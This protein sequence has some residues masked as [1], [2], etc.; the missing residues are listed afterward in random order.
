MAKRHWKRLGDSK[1]G[2]VEVDAN[3]YGPNRFEYDDKAGAYASHELNNARAQ[4]I[5]GTQHMI[6]E[7][8]DQGGLKN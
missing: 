2:P 3:Q 5:G 6:H 8:A 1:D 7:L 4:E